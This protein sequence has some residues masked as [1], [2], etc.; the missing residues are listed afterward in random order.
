MAVE[1]RWTVAE[2]TQI[3]VE[4]MQMTAECT[5]MIVMDSYGRDSERT[6]IVQDM[7]GGEYMT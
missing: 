1:C 6:L 4:H 7:V 5:W 2:C 3:T